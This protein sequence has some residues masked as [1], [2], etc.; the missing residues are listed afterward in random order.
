MIWRL[1]DTYH[2]AGH[3]RG[4]ATLKFYEGRD[5]LAAASTAAAR[6]TPPAPSLPAWS[7]TGSH[8]ELW[9]ALY[10][11]T[12]IK[13]YHKEGRALRTETTINNTRDFDINKRLMNLP[14]LRKIGFHANRRLLDVQRLS[15]DCTIGE[16]AFRQVNEPVV[17]DGHGPAPCVSPIRWCRR[18]SAR[19]WCFV[20]CLGVFPTANSATTGLPCWEKRPSPL[21][22]DK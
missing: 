12:K 14:A 4:T 11:N 18:C 3:G 16:D 21:T 15:H 13:Q 5:I 9:T 7:L 22:P 2:S 8:P 6:I 19:C 20:C 17:V 10:K 1:P